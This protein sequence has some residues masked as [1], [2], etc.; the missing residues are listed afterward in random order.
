MVASE[1]V[2][3]SKTGGLADVTGSL[4]CALARLGHSV[5]L[6]LPRYRGVATEGPMVEFPV[7]LSGRPLA[8]GYFQQPLCEGARAVLV[9]CPELYDRE[10]LYGPEPGG[11][12]DNCR[13]FA[14]L[15]RFALEFAARA[16]HRFSILHAHDW[17]AGLAPVYLKTACAAHPAL[18]GTAS[19]LTIHNLAYQGLCPST[20]LS[21]LDLGPEVLTPEGLEYWGAIS[22]LKAG[23]NFADS[24]TTVSPTY[25]REIQTPEYGFGFE[26]ILARRASDLVGVL[27]GIDMDRWD[28]SRD[29]FLREPYDAG[30][31][32][33]KRAAKID[34]LRS[35]GLPSE[36]DEADR[37]LVGMV[38]RLVD[39]KGMDLMVAI[40]DRLPRLEA[41]VVVLGSGEER[42][43]E[44]WRALAARHPDRI[45]AH[46][47][48]DERQA[49]LVEAGA[50]IFLMPS[51]FEPCGLNQMYSMRYGTVPVVRATGGLEDTVRDYNTQTGEG[52][53]FKFTEYTPAAL[54]AALNR[55]LEAFRAPGI[56]MAIQ[57]AGM[58]Q[59]FSWNESARQYVQVYWR[60]IE[61][62]GARMARADIVE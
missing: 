61:A 25:A 47:G 55:A 34:L 24:L 46:I 43:Q 27:N 50:D 10:T 30:H 3:F 29:P 22:F 14:L 33:K 16:G 4:T 37:P 49:H 57:Q 36:G 23:V 48:F 21:A 7:A 9:E 40:A 19:V 44:F 39:Q 38:T 32:A 59:D 54:L 41:S 28:P 60:V 31:L 18:A 52:T 1:G 12:P 15:A 5:T 56:W 11:Y 6:V 26:G 53:G 45:A 8:A 51:R 20:W 35:V 17:H 62:R 42:Y 58:G 2:P 13:R